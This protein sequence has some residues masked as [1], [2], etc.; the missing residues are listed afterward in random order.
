MPEEIP[1]GL[2]LMKDIQHQID[3][4]PGSVLSNKPTYKMSPNKHEELKRQV[5]DLLDKGGLFKK[6]K[7]RV[8]FLP[9]W[10]L[11]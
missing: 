7:V 4:I 5:D 11:M 10:Y 2:P 8:L 3:L 6:V 9:F 1:H